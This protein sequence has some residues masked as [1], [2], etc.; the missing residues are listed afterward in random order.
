MLTFL[1]ELVTRDF[2]LKL[3]SLALAVLIWIVIN[4]AIQREGTPVSSALRYTTAERTFY[5]LPVVVLSS[6]ED[7][8]DF[9]VS[10]NEVTVTV[11]G[12]PK[13]FDKLQSKD[14]RVLVDL[15]GIATA[16]YLMKRVEVSTPSGVTQVKVEPEQVRIIIPPKS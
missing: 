5:N 16:N 11:Q 8:R 4:F 1:W 15:T 9:K 6:A 7:V 3:L 10:P 2:W 12:E 14:I 13:V